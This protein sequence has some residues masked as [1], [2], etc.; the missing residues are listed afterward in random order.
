MRIQRM[1]KLGRTSL[2]LTRFFWPCDLV[3][4]GVDEVHAV[5]NSDDYIAQGAT[6]IPDLHTKRTEK[7]FQHDFE[8]NLLRQK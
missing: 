5:Q 6:T 1:G 4:E 2:S 3:E 8:I 7:L